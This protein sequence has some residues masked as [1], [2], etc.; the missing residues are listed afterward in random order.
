MAS[1][2][3]WDA[4]QLPQLSRADKRAIESSFHEVNNEVRVALAASAWWG[5]PADGPDW[6]EIYAWP[7]D[8]RRKVALRLHLDE[9]TK[10]NSPHQQRIDAIRKL[11]GSGVEWSRGDLL[12]ALARAA[13]APNFWEYGP[14]A[15]P[16]MIASQLSKSQLDGLASTLADLLRLVQHPDSNFLSSDGRR[17]LSAEFGRALDTVSGEAIPAWVLHDGDGFG[18]GARVDLADVLSDGGVA[19]LLSHCMTLDKPTPSAKWLRAADRLAEGLA[20]R[21]MAAPRALV[22]RFVA[23]EDYVHD[24]HD[25]LLRGLIWT[26]SAVDGDQLTELIAAFATSAS[27]APARA[28]KYPFAP[29]AAAAAVEVLSGRSGEAPVRAL[30]RLSITVKSRT[31]NARIRTAL[32]KLAQV[33]G[34]T[35]G[36][37]MELAVADH[38]LDLNG[39]VVTKVGE[40]EATVEIADE[41]VR[42]SFARDGKALKA[43]PASIKTDHVETL[44]SLRAFVKEISKTLASEHQRVESI[45]AEDRDWAYADWVARYL[46]HPITRVF[47]RRLIWQVCDGAGEWR[48]GLPA[49]DSAVWVVKDRNGAPV[50]GDRVRL[51][52][53]ARAGSEDVSAWRD[54]MMA[55]SLRQPIKQAFREVYVLTPA[56]ETTRTY[57]NRYAGHILRYRQAAALLATRGWHGNFLGQWDGGYNGE[58]TKEFGGA[59]RAAFFY[60]LVENQVRQDYEARFCSTDQVRF[61]RREGRGWTVVPVADVPPLVFTEAMR[62]VDLFVGVTSIAADPAWADRGEARFAN[63]WE[64][65]IFGE[66]TA[67]ATMRKDVLSRVLPRL[68][69]ADRA[70]LTGRFLR[71]RGNLRTYK[72]HL[73]SGNILME[74]NDAYLCIVADRSAKTALHLPFDDDAV[75]S[76]IL[77]KALLLAA[78]D[79]IADP[80]ITRQLGKQRSA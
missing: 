53:P 65:T 19:D 17:R 33:R 14:L 58:S 44:K 12:W 24:D 22:G 73:G 47:G 38:G 54:H 66:L 29:K 9:S 3:Q 51:W 32:G 63:Y 5:R 64:A 34:W 11:G 13:K 49:R 48:A 20:D 28:S 55:T 42:L 31:L 57:S 52:H 76:M 67:S 21:R 37:A 18:S 6:Q 41:K 8:T 78:D 15:L 72:I 56:E 71:V 16:A 70:E 80:T 60:D 26:M 43:V 39:R 68:K 27:A 35:L 36:E 1:R 45:F 59:W 23:Y 69:I 25:S 2:L 62:D 61:S 40:Y 74:P 30:A 7:V 4:Q 79:K 75:L 77:S 10:R 46:E 50:R